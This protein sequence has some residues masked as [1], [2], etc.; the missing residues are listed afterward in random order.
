MGNGNQIPKIDD[1]KQGFVVSVQNPHSK[2]FKSFKLYND[3][4]K[5]D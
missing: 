5:T 3:K 4:Q 2:Q 1:K